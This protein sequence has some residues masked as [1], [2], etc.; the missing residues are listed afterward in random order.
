[1]CLILKHPPPLTARVAVCTLAS[2]KRRESLGSWKTRRTWASDPT[3]LTPLAVC[4]SWCRTSTGTGSASSTSGVW[5]FSP[6]R[7]SWATGSSLGELVF[8]V[9]LAVQVRLEV[10]VDDVRCV[11]R[12][13]L[14]CPFELR[15]VRRHAA[16]E[17]ADEQV[18]QLFKLILRLA[19]LGEQVGRVV[20]GRHLA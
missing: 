8:P 20:L 3:A 17:L 4:R 5:S 1:M 13:G 19:V 11:L 12:G 2:R 10:L 14:G 7:P 15:R 18:H 9:R 6:C 16:A